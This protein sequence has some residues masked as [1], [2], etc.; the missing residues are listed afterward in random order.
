MHHEK[1]TNGADMPSKGQMTQQRYA[2][3][4]EVCVRVLDLALLEQVKV[5][6]RD[7]KDDPELR[8]QV[9]ELLA[10]DRVLRDF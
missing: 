9:E 5:L 2:K 4:R 7:C 6:E 3:L 1:S 8:D 10:I